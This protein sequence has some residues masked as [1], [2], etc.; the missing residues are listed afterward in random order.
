MTAGAAADTATA[1]PAVTAAGEGDATAAAAQA[2]SSTAGLTV[3]GLAVHLQEVLADKQKA[4]Q[5]MV[6]VRSLSRLLHGQD[7]DL[8]TVH[9]A[10]VLPQLDV[11]LQHMRDR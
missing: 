6:V 1:A 7:V 2:S 3:S 8:S 11:L 9:V 4:K 5:H 10:E